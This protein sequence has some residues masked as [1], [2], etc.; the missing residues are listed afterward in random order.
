MLLYTVAVEQIIRSGRT[1]QL[2]I[3]LI[4]AALTYFSYYLAKGGKSWQIRPL[5]GLE[6]M[7]ESIGRCAEMGKSIMVSTGISNLQNAQTMAGLT[8]L[9]EVTQKA[10]E[11]GVSTT[12]CASSQ[13]V[14]I[15][16]EAI[17]K[18]ALTAAGKSELYEPGKYVRWYG[19]DQFSYA[20]GA[21]GQILEEKPGL[22]VYCGHF[23][24]D[25]LVTGETGAR[26]GAIQVGASRGSLHELVV[27]CDYLL[28]GDEMFAMSAE[29]TGDSYVQGTLAAQDWIKEILIVLGF[30][31]VIL[32]A[33]GSDL[34]IKLL[35]M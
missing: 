19:G 23:L 10:A 1:F 11:L 2:L 28:M 4:I 20:V 6:A 13:Q 26:V 22:V 21:S 33:G 27:M 18:N 3:L 15:S 17:I 31:G 32:Y 30:I 5:E 8:V 7:R 14:V 25:C 29:I 16:S 9:G 35:G 12:T 24:A 34:I